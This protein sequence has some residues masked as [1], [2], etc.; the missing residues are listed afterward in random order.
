MI[1]VLRLFREEADG[2]S[3]KAVDFGARQVS[4]PNLRD[5]PY[6]STPDPKLIL[7][8]ETQAFILTGSPGLLKTKTENTLLRSSTHEKDRHPSESLTWVGDLQIDLWILTYTKTLGSGQ[9]CV[10]RKKMR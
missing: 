1:P 10:G 6:G 9:K 7:N 2:V 3:R 4:Q 5:D 8:P